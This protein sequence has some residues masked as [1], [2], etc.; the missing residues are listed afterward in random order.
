MILVTGGTGL[1]GMHLL[2]ALTQENKP[3]RATFRSLEK[4]KEVEAFFAFA[5]AEKQ[6]KPIDWIQA[7]ITDI[8][9]LELA[10]KDITYV[11]HCAALISFD[12]YDFQKLLK[13]NVEGTANVVN[14][15]IAN[16][17]EKLC[18][19]SSI[20]ALSKLPNNPI[21]EE[22]IWDPNEANSVYGISKYGAEM[23]V[24]RGTQEGLKAIIFNPVI[25]LGEG[26]YTKG[27]GVLCNYALKEKKFYSKGS[28][29]FIDVKDVVTLMIKGLNSTITKERYILVGENTS[30]KDI[31]H[32]MAQQFSKRP[33]KKPLSNG[34]LTILILGDRF[35]GLFTRKRKITR[36]SAA[37]IQDTKVFSS[38]KAKQQ[39]SYIP[40][41]IDETLK[42]IQHHIATTKN[43]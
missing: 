3:V 14:L 22:N 16:Q 26:D 20:A 38:E 42:R 41:P 23:E 35:I 24:W 40:T 9:S 25:I 12:P 17:I 4:V 29:G 37:S 32:R 43:L 15:C 39:L 31:L 10:F 19:L 27:S 28:N 30:Y 34:I 18:Y 1:V 13:T 33:P 8:P 36:I 7:D 6:F 2:L 21:N 11:Y 5:K